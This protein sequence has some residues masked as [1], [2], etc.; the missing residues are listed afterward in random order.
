MAGRCGGD[1]IVADQVRVLPGINAL[2]QVSH[3]G[4]E[5]FVILS[6]LVI[7]LR[8]LL[9]VGARR[10]ALGERTGDVRSDVGVFYLDQCVISVFVRH[11]APSGPR[12]TLLLLLDEVGAGIADHA[13]IHRDELTSRVEETQ[14][15]GGQG[16]V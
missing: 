14:D 8:A 16:R 2:F 1:G 15:V 9:L 6:A 12:P 4:G 7:I 10:H 5:T 11:P 13:A 3:G